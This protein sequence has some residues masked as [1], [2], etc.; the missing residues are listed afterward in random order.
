[1]VGGLTALSA[2]LYSV[3]IPK[4]SVIRYETAIKADGFIVMVHG[5]SQEAARAKTILG[6][7]NATSVESHGNLSA[8]GP[9]AS[10]A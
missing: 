1:M 7:A 8:P 3:G 5:T 10:A 2:A 4:D 9:E 6:I